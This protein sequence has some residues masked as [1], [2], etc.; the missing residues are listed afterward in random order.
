MAI[1]KFLAGLKS[2]FEPIRSQILG[3]A[4]LPSLAETYQ[5]VLRSTSRVN[6]LGPSTPITDHSALV[7]QAPQP[8]VGKG[9]GSPRHGR[10]GYRGGYR[11]GGRGRGGRPYCTN[12]DKDGH[13][14]ETCWDL[15]GR[16]ARFAHAV[17]TSD[18]PPPPHASAISDQISISGEEYSKFLQLQASQHASAPSTSLAH[19]GTSTACFTS[20]TRPWVIESVATDHLTGISTHFST[21]E[22]SSSLPPITLADGSSMPVEGKGTVQLSPSLSLSSVLFISRSPFNLMPVRKLTKEL[23]ACVSFSPDSILIQD[24][25]TRKT[26]G[27]GHE[28]DSLYYF[29]ALPTSTPTACPATVSP[30]QI[31]C[32]LGHPSLHNLKLLV[33][34]LSHLSTLE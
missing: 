26:I 20:H 18:V 25:T 9:D 31:H 28:S 29:D 8:V 33:P 3:G 32:R 1:M 16:P 22:S 14:K 5:R 4:S 19:K 2:D 30:H 10:G 11:G 27:V 15:I 23:N 17:V 6:D 34:S 12:C 13:T 24:L 21:L 7:T